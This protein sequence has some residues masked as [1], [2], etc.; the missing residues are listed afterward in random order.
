MLQAC[1]KR[2]TEV[3]EDRRHVDSCVI[4]C[5]STEAE[6]DTVMTGRQCLE[7]QDSESS[8]SYAANFTCQPE[9]YNTFHNQ[10]HLH[11]LLDLVRSSSLASQTTR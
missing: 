2:M 1:R 4:S 5:T 9:S 6:T 10:P 3:E 8:E 7:C 11:S